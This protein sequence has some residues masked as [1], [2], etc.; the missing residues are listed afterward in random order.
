MK[1]NMKLATTIAV[2]AALFGAVGGKASTSDLTDAFVNQN[3]TRNSRPADKAISDA[4]FS[5][6]KSVCSE[7]DARVEVSETIITRLRAYSDNLGSDA[8]TSFEAAAK[9]ASAREK[10]LKNSLDAAAD[11]GAGNWE[12]AR[13]SVAV[14]YNLYVAAATRAETLVLARIAASASATVASIVK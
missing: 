9:D 1:T 8:R 7:I 10:D 13:A 3:T 6:R 4:M 2:A 11:A 5:A 12:A 14:N